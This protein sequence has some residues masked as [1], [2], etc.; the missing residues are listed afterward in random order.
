M[1]VHS[2]VNNLLKNKLGNA[3]LSIYSRSGDTEDGEEYFA[4]RAS[5]DPNALEIME[6]KDERRARQKFL[7]KYFALLKQWLNRFEFEFVKQLYVEGRDENIVFKK[8]GLS[9]KLFKNNLQ[10]K[11]AEHSDEIQELVERSEWKDAELF[12][13]CFLASPATISRDENLC[14][15]EPKTVKGFGNL[16][17]AIINK[18]H[19]E[20]CHKDYSR[21]HKQGFYYGSRIEID[22]IYKLLKKIKSL[23]NSLNSK[24]FDD[25]RFAYE[26]LNDEQKQIL[27]LDIET[28]FIKVRQQISEDIYSLVSEAFGYYEDLQKSDRDKLILKYFNILGGIVGERE[29]AQ[30]T[31]TSMAV[32]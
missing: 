3:P 8:L 10:S 22:N 24:A 21:G 1:S 4:R 11:L 31:S 28:V 26:S 29:T 9:P 19:R 25:F 12:S 30:T 2:E 5:T 20:N 32:E 27:N 6:E 7:Y 15:S 23:I 14:V 17:K 16:I 13:R 18:E